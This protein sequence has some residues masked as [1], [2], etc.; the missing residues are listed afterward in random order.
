[1]S[2]N[3]AGIVEAADPAR[4]RASLVRN[5]FVHLGDQLEPRVVS[6][7][8]EA[9]GEAL[10]QRSPDL[11]RAPDGHVRKLTYPLDKHPAF[12]VALAHPRILGLALSLSPRPE[13][14]VLTWED[15][16]LKPAGIGLHVEVHQDLALQWHG[17][18]VFSLGVHLD[19]AS[20]NPVEFSPGSHAEG[21]LTRVQ[22]RSHP[23]PFLPVAPAVGDIVAHDVL[24]VHRSA[25]NRSPRPRTTWYLEFRTLGQL[26]QGPWSLEWALDRRA[27]LFHA[28]A[29]RRDAG[30][31]AEWPPLGPGETLA[32][33][34][35]RP[36]RLRIPH[37]CEGVDYDPT[38]PW[39]HFGEDA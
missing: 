19:D 10:A 36:R 13:Q 30:L 35:E 9:I 11:L 8:R 33:W 7:L 34:L 31:E 32:T 25:P 6:E 17:G 38:S 37:V 26:A 3:R 28:V 23:G 15:V 27:L 24:V 2:A 18:G 14:M 29:A 4:A 39:F 1:M 12:M 22:V 20:L 5:G 16:L 21:P